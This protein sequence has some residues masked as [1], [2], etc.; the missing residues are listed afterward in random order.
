MNN[1]SLSN[2][3]PQNRGLQWEERP[4][5]EL[6]AGLVISIINNFIYC[7][8][9]IFKN[10]RK[11]PTKTKLITQK[12]EEMGKEMNAAMVYQRQTTLYNPPV[13]LIIFIHFYKH[14]KVAGKIPPPPSP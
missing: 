13:L 4:I 10:S 14:L 2:P 5:L 1:Y 3:F 8:T 6:L 7:L 9:S 11:S 12:V